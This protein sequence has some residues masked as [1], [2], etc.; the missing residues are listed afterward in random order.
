[1]DIREKVFLRRYNIVIDYLTLEILELA[2][3]T[4]LVSFFFGVS[5]INPN[6]ITAKNIS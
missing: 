2:I 4:C 6:K 5:K 3:L 1:M